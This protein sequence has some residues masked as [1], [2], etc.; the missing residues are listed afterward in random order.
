MHEALTGLDAVLNGVVGG[1]PRVPGVVAM[2]TDRRD[3]IYAGAAGER[4]LGGMPMDVETVF[5]N[6]ST[7]KAITAT[8][9]LQC[10]ED[11]LIELDVP[12]KTYAPALG[13]V[14][15]IDGFDGAGQRRTIEEF[16][17]ANLSV[18]L[19]LDTM[20][21]QVGLPAWAFSRQFKKSFSQPL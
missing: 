15:V 13:D 21:E 12:A 11:D 19:D 16:I 18:S 4:S 7:T 6:F 8:A 10:V 2:V 17:R 20:A 5:A 3:T 14:Q 9:V 1:S